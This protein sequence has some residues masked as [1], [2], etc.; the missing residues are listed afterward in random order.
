M[1]ET[2]ITDILKETIRVLHRR[3]GFADWWD[4]V[5]MYE[6]GEI[7]IEIFIELQKILFPDE[8]DDE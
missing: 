6:R 8:E 7:G 2:I 5:G 4:N 3:S 1:D